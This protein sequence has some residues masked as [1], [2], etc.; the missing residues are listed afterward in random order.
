M[1]VKIILRCLIVATLLLWLAACW[2]VI[3]TSDERIR[4]LNPS[5]MEHLALI[6]KYLLLLLPMPFL[7]ALWWLHRL[8]PGTGET[9]QNLLVKRGSVKAALLGFG[10]V[11]GWTY[12][13]LLA[14]S[15]AANLTR[16][17]ASTSLTQGNRVYIVGVRPGMML[18]GAFSA[19]PGDTEYCFLCLFCHQAH[20]FGCI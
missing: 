20:A 4:R 12:V 15:F 11:I 10:K 1:R 2:G 19:C 7:S 3:V 17:Q 14:F 6:A 13:A 5:D 18:P 16:M 9:A 8:G